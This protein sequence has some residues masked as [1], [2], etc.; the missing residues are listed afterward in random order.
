[1]STR[2]AL[3]LLACTLPGMAQGEDPGADAVDFFER[4]IRPVL[5]EHC[6]EC[7]S[8]DSEVVQ[9][10]LLL[11]SR[12]G[13]LAGGDSGPAVVPNEPQESL[14]LS[15]LTYDGFEMPPS[16]KLPESVLRDFEHWIA[17]G[18]ADPRDEPAGERTAAAAHDIDFDEAREFWA[19]Q[20]PRRHDPP[21]VHTTAWPL[22]EHDTFVLARLEAAG[23]APNEPA[24]RRTLIRRLF[25]VMLGLPPSS[26]DVEAFVADDSPDAWNTLVDSVLASPHY[27]ERVARMWLDVMRYAEDQAHVVGNN[28]SLT[29]PNASLYRDWVIDA[30]NAD[31]PYDEF[32]IRQLA[33]DT[34]E[35]DQD[36][37]HI[38]LGFLGLGPKYYRRNA[39]EVMAEEWENQIDTVTRGLL[40]LTVACA[41]CHDHKYDPIPT[42]DYYAL[43]GVFASTE[44]YNRPL[45]EFAEA[46]ETADADGAEGDQ[47]EGG[48]KKEKKKDKNKA[49]SDS[50]HL[51]RDKNPRDIHVQIR[52]DAAKPGELVKRAFLTVLSPEGPQ[53]FDD[54]SG[55]LQLAEAIVSR[56][57]PL[58]ARVIVNR[59]W[60][61][62]MGRPLVGTP[63]NFGK[64]GERPSHPELL[65]DLAV[66]FMDAGWS[67]KWLCREVLTS[68]TWRQSSAIVPAKMAVDPANALLWRMERRRLD[69]E[70]WRDSLLAASGRLDR[71]VGGPSFDPQAAESTRRTVYAKVSRLELNKMLALF[72]FPDPNV[73]APT[74]SETTTPL[75][76][77][78]VLN[79]P[80]MAT[81]AR[82]L[83][84][85][86][87]EHAVEDAER[88]RWVHQ[89]LYGR[90]V[91]EEEE[92]LA[93]AFLGGD[94]GGA[95]SRWEQ[96]AQV[97]LASNEMMVV[98]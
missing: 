17:A 29:Y 44:L 47:K 7:H 98:D 34:F 31:M 94:G 65:D 36:D 35:P 11:D 71:T 88:I 30:L 72:D 23:L 76:K 93:M 33:A 43:A 5:V 82:A 26:D 40:G 12:A 79:S 58:A 15:A 27:G 45:P 59:V 95:M 16:G 92:Q 9:G 51:V 53:R 13:L 55:R 25:L 2:A 19:F 87:R 68:A 57:N 67:L 70:A 10:G 14:L 37:A 84:K 28:E 61:M 52:G 86:C 89:E 22:Q 56:D 42:S 6:Y 81:Q 48:Q 49:P 62:L 66:R 24:E 32:V 41:R 46:D 60:A 90:P 1:M 73:H 64:L 50:A 75:Q 97:L 38:A 8:A 63:S 85:R 91:T 4:K 54:G 83:A 3:V 18:G 96:Y 39:P 20:K 69:V 78:F 21:A 80:F 77:M 74:R